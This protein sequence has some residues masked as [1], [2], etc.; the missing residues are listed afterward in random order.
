MSA[1]V[2]AMAKVNVPFEGVHF[3]VRQ[4]DPHHRGQQ[5][6]RIPG[7]RGARACRVRTCFWAHATRRREV[8]RIGEA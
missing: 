2:I 4:D 7:S 6:H 3:A 5:R 1:G 8:K